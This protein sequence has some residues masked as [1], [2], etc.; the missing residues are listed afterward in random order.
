[1]EITHK[2]R[3]PS[4]HWFQK[5]NNLA[6]QQSQ[7][8]NKVIYAS[9]QIEQKTSKQVVARTYTI[10]KGMLAA[11]SFKDLWVVSFPEK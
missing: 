5:S 11:A 4:K 6:V 3:L 1:M 8:N 10:E 7:G 9:Y 2:I